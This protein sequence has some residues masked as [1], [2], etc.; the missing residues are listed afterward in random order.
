MVDH[1]VIDV[2][3][4]A[5]FDLMNLNLHPKGKLTLKRLVLAIVLLDQRLLVLLECVLQRVDI[6]LVLFGFLID[7]GSCSKL[8]ANTLILH[9]DLLLEVAAL[10]RCMQIVLFFH[11][12]SCCSLDSC[13]VY[14]V[15]I[16]DVI[17]LLLVR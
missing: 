7:L 3:E 2:L 6:I 10:I 12:C 14:L 4:L 1:Q 17:H 13:D 5:L 8:V 11:I 15:F 9:C 16:V